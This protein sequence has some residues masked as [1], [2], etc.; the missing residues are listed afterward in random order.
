MVA[1]TA[2]PLLPRVE[3]SVANGDYDMSGDF[4]IEIRSVVRGYH[5]LVV[6]V[7]DSCDVEVEV[8]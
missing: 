4:C 7:E 3:A 8:A 5:V 6:V 2:C 1:L